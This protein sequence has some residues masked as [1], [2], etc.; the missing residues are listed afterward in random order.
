MISVTLCLAQQ[1]GNRVCLL[2]TVKL[3]RALCISA[4]LYLNGILSVKCPYYKMFFAKIM[5]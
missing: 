1:G 4:V 2:I 5:V 3:W